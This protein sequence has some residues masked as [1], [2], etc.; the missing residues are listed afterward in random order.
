MDGK[1]RY[2][3]RYVRLIAFYEY[4]D[5]AR[6]MKREQIDIPLHDCTDEDWAHF[7][8]PDEKSKVVF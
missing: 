3:P 4:R 1:T 7:Y 6:N 8:P 2:D 5:K